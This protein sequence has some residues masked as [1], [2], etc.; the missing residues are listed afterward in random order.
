MPISAP[1]DGSIENSLHVDP[2]VG[3]EIEWDGLSGSRRAAARLMPGYGCSP[4]SFFSNWTLL[5]ANSAP[6]SMKQKGKS[7]FRETRQPELVSHTS[8]ESVEFFF[9]KLFY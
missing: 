5:Y 7:V 1:P 9:K 3:R 4:V 6:R 2:V 8:K